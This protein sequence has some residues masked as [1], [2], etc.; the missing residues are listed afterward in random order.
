M[1]SFKRLAADSISSTLIFDEIDSGVSGEVAHSMGAIIKGLSDDIQTICITHLPQIASKGG[2]HFKVAKSIENGTTLT[3]I[4][5]L[6]EEERI[7]EIAQMLSGAKTTEAAL[8][9]AR[10]MLYLN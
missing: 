2:A 10:D 9:N 5:R 7:V 1:L 6:N 3:R 8:A 4:E